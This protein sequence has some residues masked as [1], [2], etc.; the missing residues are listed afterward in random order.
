MYEIDEDL[1]S[2]DDM[3]D[4]DDEMDDDDFDLMGSGQFELKSGGGEAS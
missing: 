2:N 3:D 4:D 1:L